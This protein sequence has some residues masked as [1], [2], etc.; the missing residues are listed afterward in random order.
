MY[1]RESRHI[2]R[3]LLAIGQQ[4]WA[5]FGEGAKG[6]SEPKWLQINR[7]CG[8]EAEERGNARF[9]GEK[10]LTNAQGGW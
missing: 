8:V 10:C 6:G 7:L 2:R 5:V 3:R 1:M 4:R 9:F